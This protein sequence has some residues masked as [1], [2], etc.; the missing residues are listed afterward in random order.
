MGE[1]DEF[2]DEYEVAAVWHAAGL[3]RSL[4]VQPDDIIHFICSPP[5]SDTVTA[6]LWSTPVPTPWAG[7]NNPNL[8]LQNDGELMLITYFNTA[9]MS[10]VGFNPWGSSSNLANNNPAGHRRSRRMLSN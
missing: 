8:E 7:G 3:S 1:C 6:T 5:E 10:G 9:G 4:D 2:E